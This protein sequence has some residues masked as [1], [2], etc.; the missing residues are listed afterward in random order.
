MVQPIG[1]K[2]QTNIPLLSDNADI[3]TALKVYHYGQASEPSTL[4][5]NS[6]AGHFKNLEDT[7]VDTVPTPIISGDNNLNLKTTTGYYSVPTNAIVSGGSNFPLGATAGML[8]VI[9]DGGIV[10]QFYISNV[11][12]LYWRSK[13]GSSALWLDWRE[14]A[15]TTFVPNSVSSRLTTLETEMLGKQPNVTGAATTIV[16]VNLDASKVL[17]SD[18]SGKVRASAD[19]TTTELGHLNGTTGTVPSLAGTVGNNGTSKKIFIQDPASG[20]PVAANIGDLW[21]W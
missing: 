4:L 5:A 13:F 7:K 12:K 17:V 14:A 21:F 6:V 10:Y 20:T 15:D 1:T 18:G 8:H 11:P 9:N 3:Q 16:D 19:I 2:Y